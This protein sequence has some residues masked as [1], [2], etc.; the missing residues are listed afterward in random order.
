MVII[1]QNVDKS[2]FNK[3]QLYFLNNYN[4]CRASAY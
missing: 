3:K 2:Y 1:A 4:F